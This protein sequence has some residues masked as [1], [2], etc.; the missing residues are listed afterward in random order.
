MPPPMDMIKRLF[1]R[2][3]RRVDRSAR[4][5]GLRVARV[6]PAGVLGEFALVAAVVL[7]LFALFVFPLVLVTIAMWKR[8]KIAIPATL[9]YVAVYLCLTLLGRPVLSNHGGADWRREW[10]PVG[11]VAAFRGA[12]GFGR[13]HTTLTALG[14]LYWPCV[15]ADR[16]FWH[17]TDWNIWDDMPGVVAEE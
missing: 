1:P 16:L 10:C 14:L 4:R 2:L 3:L 9:L 12:G 17:R 6:L 5:S 8:P 13:T 11:C 7:F 15:G